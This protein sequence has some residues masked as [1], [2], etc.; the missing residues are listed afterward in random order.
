MGRNR[1]LLF[2]LSEDDRSTIIGR[3]YI[4]QAPGKYRRGRQDH[5]ATELVGTIGY[6]MVDH[7]RRDVLVSAQTISQSALDFAG[8]V[9]ARSNYIYI[10]AGF[11]CLVGSY[12]W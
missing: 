4:G 7:E 2:R 5:Q 9:L 1:L 11:A 6:F 10:G 12:T 3:S 8:D